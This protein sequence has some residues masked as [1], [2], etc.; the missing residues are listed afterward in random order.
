[1]IN[2][3]LNFGDLIQ[4]LPPLHSFETKNLVE[5]MDYPTLRGIGLCSYQV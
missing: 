5:W 4:H 1:M 2:L 3:Y